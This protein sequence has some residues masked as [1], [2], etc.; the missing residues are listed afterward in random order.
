[1]QVPVGPSTSGG[2][3]ESPAKSNKRKGQKKG[4]APAQKH[5]KKTVGG[6]DSQQ[7]KKT[8]SA[9]AH[10]TNRVEEKGVGQPLRRSGR[11]KNKSIKLKRLDDNKEVCQPACMHRDLSVATNEAF[12]KLG[13]CL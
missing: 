11:D 12:N 1:M 7:H 4:P 13:I 8:Q 9:K 5:Q 2:S 10:V 3:V 6:K